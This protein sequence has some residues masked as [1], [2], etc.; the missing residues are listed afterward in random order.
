MPP[1]TRQQTIQ[2]S[3]YDYPYHHIPI[4]D[5]ERFSQAHDMYWGYEY[6]SY[7]HFVIEKIL[8]ADF[9]SVLDAGCGDGRLLCELSR[10]A[11]GKRL[12]GIDYS[13]KAIQLAAAMCPDVQWMCGDLRDPE[14]WTDAD[15]FD[16]VTL[17]ETIEHIPPAELESFVAGL[18]RR[19]KP[20][21]RLIVTAPSVNVPLHGKHFQHFTLETLSAALAPHFEPAETHYLNRASAFTLALIRKAVSN[22]FVR[23]RH[24]RILG[25]IYR[26]YVKRFLHSDAA[27]GARLALVCRPA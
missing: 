26:Y 7:L 12:V 20:E 13:S 15:E 19:I 16:V 2:E 10:R 5:G 1:S 14:L 17:I 23:L 22:R 8:A 21:G 25:W 6:L 3:R 24:E 9:D 4:W 18:R 27:R 11:A